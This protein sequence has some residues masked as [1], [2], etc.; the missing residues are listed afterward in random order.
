MVAFVLVSTTVPNLSLDEMGCKS[1]ELKAVRGKE[2]S[3]RP[4]IQILGNFGWSATP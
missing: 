3:L 2:L 1:T 4:W